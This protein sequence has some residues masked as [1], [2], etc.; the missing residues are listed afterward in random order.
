MLKTVSFHKEHDDSYIVGGRK[1]KKSNMS[2]HHHLNSS[3]YP[4]NLILV[5]EKKARSTCGQRKLLGCGGSIPPPPSRP[6]IAGGNGEGRTESPSPFP[7]DEK[8]PDTGVDLYHRFPRI[9]V[10]STEEGEGETE[11]ERTRETQKN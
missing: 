6:K 5:K 3:N 7:N 8:N 9:T 11:R 1:W 10:A 2:F 4:E